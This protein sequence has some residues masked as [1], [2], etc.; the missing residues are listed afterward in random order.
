MGGIREGGGWGGPVEGRGYG[1]GPVTPVLGGGE[2]EGG[3]GGGGW[4]GDVA[5]LWQT[6]IRAGC[7]GRILGLRCVFVCQGVG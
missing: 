7:T 1:D 2:A 3:E 4:G 5:G 6:T